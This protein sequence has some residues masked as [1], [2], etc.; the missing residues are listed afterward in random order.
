MMLTAGKLFAQDDTLSR[1]IIFIG[2]AGEQKNGVHPELEYLKK[3]FRLDSRVTIVYL[4]DNVYPQG[5]PSRYAE[6]Y[7]EKKQILDSQINVV[8][9][10]QATAYFI[11]GNHDWMQ[12][13]KDGYQQI[14]NQYRYIESRNLPN[15]HFVPDNACPGPQEIRLSNK[16]TLVVIDS[17]W[18]LHRYEKPGVGS[19]CDCNTEAEM[20]E[21]LDDIV[22]RNEDKLLL[23]AAH[24]PFITFGRHGGY[25][26]LKAHIFPFTDLNPSLYIPLPVIGSIYPIARGVFGNIQDTRHPLYKNF[27]RDVDSILS[28]HPNCIRLAGHEHNLQFIKQNDQYYVV[29]GAGSKHADITKDDR[30][31]FSSLKS[32]FAAIDV[33][34]N[35]NVYVKFFSS[36]SDS[37]GAPLFVSA[38]PSIDSTQMVTKQ[39]PVPPLPDSVTVAAANYYGAR[40]LKKWLMGEN[41]RNEWMQPVKVKVF[42]IGAEGGGMKVIRENREAQTRSLELED[43]RGNGYVL[44]S[45]EKFPDATLPEEFRQTIIKDA[46]IDAFSASYPYAALSVAPLSAK[47]HP[48][49]ARPQLVYIPDDP[50]LGYYQEKFAHSLAIFEAR[51]PKKY[52]ENKSTH[53]VLETIREDNDGK[54]DQHAVLTERLLD[55]FVMDFNRHEDQW[56]WNANDTGKGKLYHPVPRDR[57]QAFYVNMGVIPR[58]LRKPWRMPRLQGFGARAININTFNYSARDFDRTFLNS[59]TKSDWTRQADSFIT[60]MSDDVIESALRKQ[61]PEIFPYSGNEITQTLKE[62]RNY[63]KDEVLQYYKFL[64]RE[65]EITGSD[66]N[67]LFEVQNKDD[68]SS[69][70]SVFKIADKSGE[71]MLTYNRRFIPQ[72]TK[73]IRLFGLD[74]K[75]SFHI[76]GSANSLIRIRLLGGNGQDSYVNESSRRKRSTIAY[77]IK[78]DTDRFIG[79]MKK[80]ISAD[81]STNIYKRKNFQYDILRPKK[82]FAYNRDD[83]LFLGAGLV[84][85]THGFRKEPFRMRQELKGQVAMLTWAYRFQYDLELTDAV[86]SSDLVMHAD[87]RVPNNNINYFGKGNN[88]ENNINDGRGAQYYRTRFFHGD[89]AALLRR[90]ILP[91]IN[92]Y[93]GPTFQAFRADSIDN[94]E[95]VIAYPHLAGLDSSTLYKWKTYAGLATRL[96]IDNRNDINYPTR[97]VNWV[98]TAQFN[99]GLNGYSSNFS[100]LKSDL[101][102]YISSNAP[103][104]TVV[105]VRFGAGFNFGKYEFYQSQFLSGLDNLR[106]Y[107]KFR[108]AGDKM[109]YNNIDIRIRLKNYQGYLFT[110][111]YGILLF[112]DIGRVWVKGETSG[113][114][115]NGYGI[116]AWVSPANRFVLTA[117]YMRSKEGALPLVSLGF[118]F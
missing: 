110:G 31:L 48:S 39:K 85:T 12:G 112:H 51:E 59:L 83:G 69:E 74:G 4:G 57:D 62:R 52:G 64:S 76:S 95:R 25:Y 49:L 118:Q 94:V 42:D 50:R 72:E 117:S 99:R 35:G 65:V 40:P 11:A 7:P 82:Y 108:F 67:E 89:F 33:T 87:V 16:V 28:E 53:A 88:T 5:L 45:V 90:E 23:F 80:R 3:H 18:W 78:G 36:E 26:N 14:I 100:Q 101:S 9:G 10:K 56:Q 30:L 38:L 17:Q 91:D 1:R 58:M 43:S 29:S 55:M 81:P 102:I 27:I 19:G 32:G 116:G 98:T 71:R 97:G 114:W 37:V 44:R 34:T 84:Y 6:N 86:G 60:N 2:D 66:K 115:H 104:R 68:G 61:P 109:F 92:F 107:R 73:E 8:R 20:L 22:H 15:V 63:L 79:N 13:R 75:D 77:D 111:S 105:A 113:R 96:V 46:V 41:Y 70:V 103:P 106:G 24:H 93:Y 21:R 47:I 54:V